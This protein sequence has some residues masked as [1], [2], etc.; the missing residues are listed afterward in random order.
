MNAHFVCSLRGEALFFGK[1]V[2]LVCHT[3]SLIMNIKKRWLNQKKPNI[4][5]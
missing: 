3:P 4:N 5:M 2:W 1:G